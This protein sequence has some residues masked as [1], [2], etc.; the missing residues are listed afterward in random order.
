MDYETGKNFEKVQALLEEHEQKLE[1]LMTK[2]AEKPLQKKPAAKPVEAVEEVEA[3]DEAV[4]DIVEQEYEEPT[5]RPK[6]KKR[7]GIR[8]AKEEDEEPGRIL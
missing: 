4:D 8:P 7:W 5:V 6:Q 2:L 1:Y 3:E